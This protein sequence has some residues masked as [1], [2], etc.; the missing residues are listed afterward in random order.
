MRSMS[1]FEPEKRQFQFLLLFLSSKINKIVEVFG[2]KLFYAPVPS[3][4]ETRVLKLVTN[5]S[6]AITWLAV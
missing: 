1:K 4:F 6:I 2:S 5:L 3:Y